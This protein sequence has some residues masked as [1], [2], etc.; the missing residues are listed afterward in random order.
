MISKE[1]QHKIL[2]KEV[3]ECVIKKMTITEISDKLNVGP[4]MIK[5]ALKELGCENYTRRRIFKERKRVGDRFGKL[6]LLECLE[7][8]KG[9]YNRGGLWKCKCDCGTIINVNGE[10]LRQSKKGRKSCGCLYKDAM[11]ER[12]KNSFLYETRTINY[13]YRIHCDLA[14]DKNFVPLSKED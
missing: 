13:Q 9:D 8:S 4:W 1:E 5:G 7:E 2:L 14:I 6:L 3:K 10:N 11:K 12:A